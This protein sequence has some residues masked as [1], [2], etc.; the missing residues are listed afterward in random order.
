MRKSHAVLYT[1]YAVYIVNPM[2][3]NNSTNNY[4]YCYH[5]L[6]IGKRNVSICKCDRLCKF[7]VS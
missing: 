5:L 2:E 6:D 7:P 1:I 4:H 3:R